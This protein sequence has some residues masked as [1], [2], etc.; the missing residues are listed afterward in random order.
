MH[1]A[2]VAYK[3]PPCYLKLQGEEALCHCVPF[4]VNQPKALKRRIFIAGRVVQVVCKK[5][6]KEGDSVTGDMQVKNTSDKLADAEQ[7]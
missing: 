3:M 6:S 2:S 5:D 1:R 4:C 7:T